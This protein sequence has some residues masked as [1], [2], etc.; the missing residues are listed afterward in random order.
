MKRNKQGFIRLAPVLTLILYFKQHLFITR[1]VS[2]GC[3]CPPMSSHGTKQEQSIPPHSMYENYIIMQVTTSKLY[4]ITLLNYSDLSA[5]CLT[6]Y[7]DSKI[8]LDAH[9]QKI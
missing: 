8:I 4:V 5:P 6:D 2:A 3:G 1:I 9:E 7:H